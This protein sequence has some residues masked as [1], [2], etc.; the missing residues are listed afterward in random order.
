MRQILVYEAKFFF[1][2]MKNRF[3]VVAKKILPRN[4]LETSLKLILSVENGF[5][6]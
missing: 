1:R 3:E 6:G 2:A 4:L 5:E